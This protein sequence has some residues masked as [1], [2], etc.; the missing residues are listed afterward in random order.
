MNIK[1]F[2]MSPLIIVVIYSILGISVVYHVFVLKPTVRFLEATNSRSKN[3]KNWRNGT[4]TESSSYLYK[5]IY[6]LWLQFELLLGH[7]RLIL[8]EKNQS[9]VDS[10]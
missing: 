10:V 1:L 5:S 2:D 8:F 7:I 9:N 6:M 3:N 4:A